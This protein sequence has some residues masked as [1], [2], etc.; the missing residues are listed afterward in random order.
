MLWVTV[1]GESGGDRVEVMELAKGCWLNCEGATCQDKTFRNY[2][3]A[4]RESHLGLHQS[5]VTRS[6]PLSQTL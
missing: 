3:L 4:S 2:P 5:T 1:G 6:Q